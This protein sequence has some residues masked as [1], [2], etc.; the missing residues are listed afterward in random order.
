MES[1]P[2]NKTE[3][4]LGK[5]IGQ[6]GAWL[7]AGIQQRSLPAPAVPLTYIIQDPPLSSL[8]WFI[9]MLSKKTGAC[10]GT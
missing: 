5:D 9:P 2:V 8:L 4:T 1:T 3:I 7:W 6:R 10:G